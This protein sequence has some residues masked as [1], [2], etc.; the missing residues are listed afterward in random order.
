MG[1]P[2]LVL[3]VYRRIGSWI[4]TGCHC[5]HGYTVF[6]RTNTDTQIATNTLFIDYLKMSLAVYRLSDRLM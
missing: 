6:D 2:V 5:L 4:D 3:I 1:G